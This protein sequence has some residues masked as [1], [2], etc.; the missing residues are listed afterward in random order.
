MNVYACRYRGI[1]GFGCKDHKQSWMFVPDMGQLSDRIHRNLKLDDLQFADEMAYEFELDLER[2]A[3]SFLNGIKRAFQLVNKAGTA[4]T[5]E[6][7]L[8]AANY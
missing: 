5:V 4:S 1:V 6:G 8:L 3:S 2:N 7:Q